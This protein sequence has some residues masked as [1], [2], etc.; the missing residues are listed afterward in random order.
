[1]F[2]LV[3]GA[4]TQLGPPTAAVVPPGQCVFNS[5]WRSAPLLSKSAINHDTM[6]FA[7]GLPAGKSLCLSTCA[8]IVAKAPDGQCVDAEGKD[9]ARPY[10]PIST[11]AMTG[12]FLLMVKVYSDGK[13]SAHFGN[14]EIG[15]TMDFKHT[16]ICVKNQYPFNPKVGMLVGG[17]GLAPMLQALHAIL[18]TPGDQTEARMLYC[19][20]RVEDIHFHK[21]LDEWA[22]HFHGK[23]SLEYILSAEPEDSAW[24]GARG[25]L[26]RDQ[27]AQMMPSPDE[28]C[29]IWICGPP[30]MYDYLCG[31]RA[32]PSLSG[33]LA[34]MGYRAEQV[35]KF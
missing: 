29:Q 19:S 25:R 8:C 12:K 2:H 27:I 5:E 13:L 1:M 32:D 17:T 20:K 11:N 24:T 6:V 15:Q 14:L 31:P 18:G 30:G 35:F 21:D 26:T 22:R 7:F 16:D 4:E 34:E 9:V 23:F 3:S 28:D 10:T 33:L